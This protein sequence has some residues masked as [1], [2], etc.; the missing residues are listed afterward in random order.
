MDRSTHKRRFILH[1]DMNSFYASVESMMD[2]ALK[3]K[4]LA[5]A[6]N[7]EERR[8]IIVTCSYEA[9]KFGVKTT[10]TLWQAKRL[11]PSLIVRRPDFPKYRMMSNR[12]F[13]LL[14]EYTNLVEPVSIDEGYLDVT[15]SSMNPVELAG[16]IQNRIY[17]EL[18]LPCSIGIAP[19]K[20]LAKMASDM[21]KPM[22]ITV[23]RK[24]E[25]STILWP[26]GVGEMHGIGQATEEKLKTF[27]IHTIGDLAKEDAYSLKHR[28]GINGIKMWERANGI[29]D[30]PVNPERASEFQSVGNSTT[31]AED[32][33][34]EP[35]I[36]R[37]FESLAESVERR[38]KQKKVVG[39]N[40]QIVI[41]YSDRKTVTRSKSLENP[42]HDKNIILK[43]AWNLF[44]KHWNGDPI[45]LLGITAADVIPRENAYKQMDLFTFEQEKKQED[46]N[47][48]VS[49]LQKKFGQQSIIRGKWKAGPS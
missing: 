47:R 19:N 23:L 39:Q 33:D 15:A 24:R 31:L 35:E 30:R 14:K 4:P 2:P 26:L 11:C 5:I 36:K 3:G 45:R 18:G 40:L 13:Q 22:G 21:K 10:M 20:F 48:L 7:P 38:M 12:M 9:R 42:F 43:M 28:F 6:G 8:G 16:E 1:V 37:V 17:H 41:R 44:K 25:M 27:N 29:D 49:D 34:H 32:L 46:V